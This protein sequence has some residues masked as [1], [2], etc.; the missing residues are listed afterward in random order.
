MKFIRSDASHSRKSTKLKNNKDRIKNF[1]SIYSNYDR[2]YVF[3]KYLFYT[4]KEILIKKI[5]KQQI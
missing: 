2:N 1:L 3:F 4:L 5:F